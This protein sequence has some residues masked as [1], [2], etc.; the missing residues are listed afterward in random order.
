MDILAKKVQTQIK[1]NSGLLFLCFV[2]IYLSYNILVVDGDQ[3]MEPMVCKPDN[4]FAFFGINLGIYEECEALTMVQKKGE[5]I[6]G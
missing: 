5:P 3:T 6:C 2:N 4:Q 1:G